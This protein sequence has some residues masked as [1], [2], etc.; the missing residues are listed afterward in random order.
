MSRIGNM[1]KQA[2]LNISKNYNL[3]LNS[4][5]LLYFILILTIGDLIYFSI[6]GDVFFIFIYLAIGYLTSFFSK[7][8]IVIMVISMTVTHILR[9]GK[10]SKNEG[11]ESNNHDPE[12]DFQEMQNEYNLN[13]VEDFQ[14]MEEGEEEEEENVENF[15]EME[16]G[17][18]EEEN[19]EN[20]QEM[21]EE[22]GE[23]ENFQEM[24]DGE[25]EEEN[26]E[27]F[28]EMEEGEEEEEN[29]ENFSDSADATKLMTAP[30]SK[31]SVPMS[32]N[33]MKSFSPV[34]ASSVMKIPTSSATKIPSSS[35][36]SPSS[37]SSGPSSSLYTPSFAPS[38]KNTLQNATA[39]IERI[40][41]ELSTSN[42]RIGSVPTG[43]SNQDML[44]MLGIDNSNTITNNKPIV[45]SGFDSLDTQTKKLL[46]TQHELMTN[47]ENLSPLLAQAEK[48]MDK[49]KGLSQ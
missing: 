6:D 36:Y 17:E 20:F 38:S 3:T 45:N 32:A 2:Q 47:M 12:S 13:G 39:E 11:M 19:V 21:E 34:P 49:F 15:Q 25:E 8:M 27:N 26:V 40:K 1:I 48:F 9:L 30:Y 44:K 16:E 7:N 24:E 22:E 28:Q 41:K 29:V 14:E 33:N 43:N 42:S 10:L 4:R 46:N 23:E 31:N 5:A 37:V 18:E 35:S